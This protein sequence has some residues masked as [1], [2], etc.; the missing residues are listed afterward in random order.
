MDTMISLKEP[1]P[2]APTIL[3]VDDEEDVRELVG[4]NL[5]RAGMKVAEA[6]DG[7]QGMKTARTLGP[8][9]IVLDVMMPGRDGLQVCAELRTDDATKGIPVLMLTAKG[10][11]PDRIAGLER[12]ADDYMAKPF[13]PRELVLRVQS[14]L[15][16]AAAS[17]DVSVLR[18]GPFEL[19]L[20]GVRLSLDG[21]AVDLTLLEFKLVHL[22]VSNRG[23]VVDRDTILREVWGYADNVRTRTLDTHIKRLREKLGPHSE[24]LQTSRG[25]GYMFK[26]PSV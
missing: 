7:L 9:L 16:R 14:L 11:T 12:G 26:S 5:R 3:I 21:N 1:M 13:S 18:E 20:P 15:R 19:D 17:S 6:A 25:F 22:L 24:W 10:Q 23:R 8:D 4:S 2:D